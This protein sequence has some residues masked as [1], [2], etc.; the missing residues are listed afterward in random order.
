M[1]GDL[2]GSQDGA[3][4]LFSPAAIQED[5]LSAERKG[6][7]M[8]IDA[9]SLDLSSSRTHSTTQTTQTSQSVSFVELVDSRM[10]V[11]S[12][13]SPAL[14]RI[15]LEDLEAVSFT[16]QFMGQLTA[17]RQMIEDVM[18]GFQERLSMDEDSDNLVLEQI[19][20]MPV[21]RGRVFQA[22]ESTRTVSVS[23]EETEQTTVTASGTVHTAD[24]RDLDFS[25]DLT[26]A[27][28]YFREDV[29]EE[30]VSGFA[31]IDPL[32]IRTDASAPLLSGGQFSFDLDMDGTPEDLPLPG[33]G[34]GFLA[35]DLNGDGVI[36]DGSELFGPSTGDGFAELAGYDLDDNQWIDENDEIFDDLILWEQGDEGMTLTNLKEAG[37]GAIY[38][39][40]ISSPFDLTSEDNELLGQVTQTSIALTEAGD[41]LP[42]QEV[43]YVSS[44]AED[45]A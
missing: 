36:N 25:L 35:L 7:C 14:T 2:A 27:R 45:I 20:I 43:D 12:R 34:T 30:T 3:G 24:N 26:M 23:Y 15:S 31:L 10:A 38:L 40:G 42:V 18:A 28:R 41:V 37:I 4:D 13:A 6:G 21:F 16:D 44:R 17:M 1:T 22:W 19:F 8:K 5:T 39:A 11:L 9:F 32:V 33:A 29:V